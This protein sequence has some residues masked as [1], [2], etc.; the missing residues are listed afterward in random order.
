MKG[1]GDVGA[2]GVVSGAL[3]CVGRRRRKEVV[4]RDV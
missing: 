3:G 1:D 4:Q 2:V